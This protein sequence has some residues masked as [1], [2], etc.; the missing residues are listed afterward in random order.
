MNNYR[1]QH[2]V[3]LVSIFI[4]IT[5]S[6]FLL[7]ETAKLP[8]PKA[9][10]LGIILYEK[11]CLA[12]H[13]KDGVGESRIP[14]GIRNPDYIPAMPLNETSHAWHHSDEQLVKTIMNGISKRNMPAWQHTLSEKEA[15]HIVAYIKSLWGPKILA[16]QGPKHM[17]CM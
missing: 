7:A 11:H 6:D 4:M 12:C 15:S 9:V 2:K 14:L 5:T 17:S 13:Q 8:N 3:L 1:I 16:C 10:E